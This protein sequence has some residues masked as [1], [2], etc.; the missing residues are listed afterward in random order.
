MKPLTNLGQPDST[1]LRS[2]IDAHHAA[3][4]INDSDVG[5]LQFRHF[6]G[7][8]LLRGV[9][10][11]GFQYVTVGVGIAAKESPHQ[12]NEP[13]EIPEVD[14]APKHVVGFAEIE[15]QYSSARPDDAFHFPQ[16]KFP[17]GQVPQTVADGDQIKTGIG[18]RNLL[19]I[20][21][22]ELYLECRRLDLG[23]WT[24]DFVPLGSHRK[25]RFAKI[26]SDHLQALAGEGKSDIPGAAAQ[27]ERAFAGPAIGEFEQ[28]LLPITMQAEALQIVNQVVAARDGGEK[29][30]HLGG[31]LFPGGIE[32]I[33]HVRRRLTWHAILGHAGT[34]TANTE[35]AR[36][37]NDMIKS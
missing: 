11:Q 18:K 21:T 14:A 19:G 31:A 25:H 37:Q 29:V 30:A 28:A 4:Q 7:D 13:F 17:V 27:I 2:I 3:H 36:A 5:E 20:T 12:R 10:F 6:G 33:R 26:Q 22:Q 8:S 24:L 1:W 16:A 15:H 34:I 35:P 9:M 23:L 32:F